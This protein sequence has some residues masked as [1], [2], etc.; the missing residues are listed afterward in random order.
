MKGALTMN[1]FKDTYMMFK[2]AIDCYSY[3]LSSYYEWKQLPKSMRA[4]GLYVQFYE[5]IT[6]AYYKNK[7]S[8]P[9][10]EEE[11]A[12]ETVIQ[13]LMKNVDKIIWQKSRYTPNYIYTVAFKAIYPLGRIRRDLEDYQRRRTDCELNEYMMYEDAVNLRFAET[14]I[15]KEEMLTDSLEDIYESAQLEHDIYIEILKLSE[16]EQEYIEKLMSE[17]KPLNKK[18]QL[19]MIA[20][21]K[22]IFDKYV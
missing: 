21:F 17:Y 15:P 16:K 6:L 14:H 18:P 22:I 19:K 20:N 1:I 13:Y 9:F 2:Q 7:K 5:Q 10:I 4:A 11:T 3:D 12:V 8:Y